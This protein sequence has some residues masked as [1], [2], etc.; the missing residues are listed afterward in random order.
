MTDPP[1]EGIAGA[2]VARLSGRPFVYNIR[3]MYP[4]MAVGG[5][6]V[7][8]GSFTAR[9]E[10]MHRWALRRAARV[11]VLGEDMRDRI[12]AKGVDPARVVISRDGINVPETLPSP[13]QSSGARDSRRFSFRSGARGEFGF[14]RRV[15]N[16]DFGC[17]NARKRRRGPRI[18]RR[19]RDEAAS[20][21]HG[22]GMPRHSLPAVSPG[23]RNAAGAFFRRHARGY[24]EARPRGRCGAEQAVSARWLRDV[25]CSALRRRN[26][27]WCA[28]FAARGC[29]L[30]ANPDDPD[31][32]RGGHPGGVA[33]LGTTAK[34]GPARPGDRIFL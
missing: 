31:E 9:W 19:G 22:R 27:T 26:A 30:A 7:R 13:G 24:R 15:A 4:D 14:L 12:V 8:P 20:G 25:P 16:A 6:I 5:S 21:G 34:H 10:A 28:S 2:L 17:A 32:R 33:R 3:D 29:G 1:I 23:E 11:I 18:H